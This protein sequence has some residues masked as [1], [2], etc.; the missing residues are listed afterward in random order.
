MKG[1]LYGVGVGPGDPR[2]MTYLAVET[3][4]NCPVI[5]VPAEG[6]EHA[7]S[8]RIAAG[9]VKGLDEKECLNLSTPM[10]KDMQVLKENYETAADQITKQLD[11][12]KDV[13]YLTLGDP[14]IYSTYIYIHRIVRARG[15]ETQIISGI[16][17]FC[18]VAAR[19]GGSLADRS[20][21]LHIIPSTYDIEEALTYPG[22]KIL[23]K[24]AS[25]LSVVK[26]R[27]KEKEMKGIMVE[28]CG[29]PDE[30]IYE[31]VDDMPE[32]ASYYSI[33]V[34]RENNHD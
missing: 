24:A 33:V 11:A 32:R 2:L 29:M 30:H 4:K 14:T 7:V 21:Q 9:I 31:N 6:R 22:S 18:A 25:K 20:E 34:V 15:Y 19:L 10:T 13:A 17:S 1:T 8:Y 28:N 3:V 12:G 26:D 23:M 16:P 27:L 5:A